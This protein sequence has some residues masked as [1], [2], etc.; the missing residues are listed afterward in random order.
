MYLNEYNSYH[1]VILFHKIRQNKINVSFNVVNVRH[2]LLLNT[3]LG[4]TGVKI[5][6]FGLKL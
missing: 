6:L 5:A 3:H 4:S 1:I 2:Y